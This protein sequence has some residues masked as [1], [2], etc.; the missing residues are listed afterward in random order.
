MDSTRFIGLFKLCLRYKHKWQNAV[1][2]KCTSQT[3]THILANCHLKASVNP[4][5]PS[6]F[7][8][9]SIRY[10]VSKLVFGDPISFHGHLPDTVFLY[11]D[12]SIYLV[13]KF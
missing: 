2:R 11:L 3:P 5:V 12:L 7:V 6:P 4:V 13:D 9:P 10:Y 8:C 1:K